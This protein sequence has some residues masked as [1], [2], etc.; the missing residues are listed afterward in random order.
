ME[1]KKVSINFFALMYLMLFAA[2]L[3]QTETRIF[4]IGDSTMA[5]KPLVDNPE[6]GWGQMLPLFF[7]ENVLIINH[8]KNGRSTKSF[9]AEGR[10]KAVQEQLHPGDYVFIQFGHND[11]KKEDTSRFAA[12]HS[13]YK[14]NLVKFIREAR[15]KSAVPVL[16]TPI[17]R[18]DFDKAGQYIGMHGDY[19][20]VMKEVAKEETVPLIDM[21]EKSKKMVSA[22]GDERSKPLYLNGVKNEF[23][24]WNKKRDNTHF[25]RSGAIEM[26][27]LAVEGI[28]ELHLP[29]EN[30]LVPVQMN[31]LAGTGKVVGLDYFFNNEW[32]VNKDSVR[33]RWH[34]I[35]EDTTNSGFSLL[36]RSIDLLG[37]DLDTL[38]CAPTDSTLNC[39]SVYIIVDPDT[40]AETDHPHYMSE[41]AISVIVP[42]VERGGVLVLMENDKGNAEFE[43][44]NKLAEHF[45]I[46][47]N[48]DSYHKV[49]GK[50]FETGKN[51]NLPDHPIFKRVRQIFT[52]EVCT[53]WIQKPAEP[54]LV[55]DSLV[56]MATAHFGKGLVFAVGDPWLYNEYMDTRRLPIDYE[57][58]KAGKNLFDWL[59]KNAAAQVH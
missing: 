19:P 37:A 13:D 44:F 26:A 55:E 38:Q 24:N 43:H 48:E 40:P 42:W 33:E 39:C 51:E 21:F 9:I 47:F 46:H 12:P 29:L 32:R 5:D 45:G 25:T 53:L 36:G 4:L 34:Y 6:H 31:N 18:R 20:A 8:A 1:I 41:D 57:N 54:V 59:L 49:V 7:H 56:L 23:R 11:A 3:P 52:K 50:A 2:W 35:W 14:N 58:A 17:T 15:E 30:E 10:W 16:L 27:S 28:K 22:L